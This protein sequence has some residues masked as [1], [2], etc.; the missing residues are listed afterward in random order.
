M[1]L[2]IYEEIQLSTMYPIKMLKLIKSW[3]LD[4]IHMHTELSV[5]MFAKL[6]TKQHNIPLIYTYHTIYEKSIYYMTKG[7][8]QKITKEIMLHVHRLLC[9]E[10]DEI[11]APGE[12]VRQLL[13]DRYGVEAKINIVPNGV[14][15]KRFYKEKTSKNVVEAYKKDLG[16][17]E[18]DFIIEYIGRLSEEKSIEFIVSCMKKIVKYNKNIKLLLVGDGPDRKRLEN[19]AK[20]NKIEENIIF[21][22]RVL[23]ESIPEYYQ[24]GDIFDDNRSNGSIPTRCMY[25]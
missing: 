13:N 11:I 24:L 16:I 15:V 25:R 5:G 12:K 20:R 6:Y 4:V 17:K 3:N 14:D 19:I 1:T 8:F 22:G 23:W 2:G 10:I 7:K 21:A 18:K 9:K